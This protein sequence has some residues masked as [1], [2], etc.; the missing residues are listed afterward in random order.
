MSEMHCALSSRPVFWLAAYVLKMDRLAGQQGEEMYKA[1]DVV[2]Y[3][4]GSDRLHLLLN[5]VY[6]ALKLVMTPDRDNLCPAQGLFQVPV[7]QRT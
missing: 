1:R 2:R 3:R 4:A 7:Q 6:S 5:L